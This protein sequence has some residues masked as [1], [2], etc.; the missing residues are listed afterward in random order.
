VIR[1]KNN[2]LHRKGVG[3]RGQ[4][5]KEEKKERKKVRKKDSNLQQ[6]GCENLNLAKKI[7][8]CEKAMVLCVKDDAIYTS[9]L[10]FAISISFAFKPLLS[11][12]LHASHYSGCR[13]LGDLNHLMR[14]QR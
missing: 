14:Q 6:H 9:K 3:R 8:I 12:L 5:K 4:K 2:P 1:C 13:S 11:I 7:L 10:S